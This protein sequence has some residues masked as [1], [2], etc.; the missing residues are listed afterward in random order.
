MLG[1]LA[2]GDDVTP[3]AERSRSDLIRL[4]GGE[5]C[6]LWRPSACLLHV[7]LAIWPSGWIY[8]AGCVTWK[9]LVL[10]LLYT[11]TVQWEGGLPPACAQDGGERAWE[12][13]LQACGRWGL[14]GGGLGWVASRQRRWQLASLPAAAP[15]TVPGSGWTGAT[16]DASCRA[17]DSCGM[18]ARTA[19][20]QHRCATS[21]LPR[22]PWHVLSAPHRQAPPA[23]EL[24]L[25]TTTAPAGRTAD[26]NQSI[27]FP[28]PLLTPHPKHDDRAAPASDVGPGPARRRLHQ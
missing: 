26:N 13:R 10:F 25:P 23:P 28:L 24:L 8:I 3:N 14:H 20:S 17:G 16:D 4:R 15:L 2:A 9:G 5:T 21:S 19:P 7:H 6:I 1:A 12:S 22:P 18:C 11:A 27:C